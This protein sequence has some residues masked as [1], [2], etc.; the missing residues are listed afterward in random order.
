M[1]RGELRSRDMTRLDTYESLP[2]VTYLEGDYVFGRWFETMFGGQPAATTS[3]HHFD[4]LEEVIA[5]VAQGLGASI[6]PLDSVRAAARRR[7]IRIIRPI[8]G[9]PCMN[10][11]FAVTRAGAFVRM[12]FEWV[13]RVLGG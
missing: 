11:I 2:L 7:E 3:V 12:E 9:S 5:V 8:A 1:V 13:C 4:E 6:V 10:A